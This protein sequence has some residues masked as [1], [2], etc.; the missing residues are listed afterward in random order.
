MARWTS[1]DVQ[2]VKR[3]AERQKDKG[4]TYQ[5]QRPLAGSIHEQTFYCQVI[6]WGLAHPQRE[7]RFDPTRRWRFDF[8][9][10]EKHIAVE[11]EGGQWVNGRHSRGKGFE[12]D[13][14]KYL[15][16]LIQGW[17]VVRA[18]PAMINDGSVIQFVSNTLT[19]TLPV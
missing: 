8:A 1:A 19:K 6:D 7:Y 9:W 14:R 13:C 3:K 2:A 5:L 16:A 12:A 18:T 4:K 10:P 17:T 15:A 11:I